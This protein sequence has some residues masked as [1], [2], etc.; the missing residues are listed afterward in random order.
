MA[1]DVI[2]AAVAGAH[3]IGGEVRLKL[4]AEGVDSLKRHDRVM[5]G[6]KPLTIISLKPGAMPIVRFEGVS[7]RNGAEALRSQLVTIPRAALP[8][9]EE[10]EYYHADLIG[11]PCESDGGDPLGRVVAVENFGAGDILE[12]EK[13]DGRRTMVPFRPGIAD[14]LDRRIVVDPVFLA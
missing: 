11:L 3:G 8:P 13:P 14:L 4:F 1:D 12:I 7:D 9:L 10:G 5:V 6:G 2:L